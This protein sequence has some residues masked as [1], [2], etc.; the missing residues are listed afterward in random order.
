MTEL[1][2]CP[3]VRLGVTYRFGQMKNSV[4]KA[5]R[6]INND[7]LKS[8]NSGTSAGSGAVGGGMGSGSGM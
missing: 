8:G 6:S 5:R 4:K 2:D 7:D 1:N 3:Y